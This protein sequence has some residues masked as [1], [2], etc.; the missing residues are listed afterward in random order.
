MDITGPRDGAPHKVGAAIGDLVSGSVRGAGHPGGALCAQ[1]HRARPACQ[2]LHV[3]GRGVAADLQ[4]QH[5]LRHRQLAAPPR[6]RASHHRALRD[7]RGG[8]RLDQ[9]GRRQRRSVA[10][11]LQRR[12]SAT[13]LNERS[14]ASPRRRIACATARSSCRWSGRIIKERTRDEWLQRLDKAGVP[15]GAIRTVGEVCDSDLLKA[16]GMIAEMPHASAGTVKAIKNAVHLSG[17]PLDGY[18]AP[19]TLGQ[20]TREVLTGLLG[21]TARARSMRWRG[22]GDLG[23]TDCNVRRPACGVPR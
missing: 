12:R 1:G 18:V 17:T 23:C 20:H 15:S 6:Q 22:Q 5:L 10:A 3:R 9:S 16:R 19:P 4:R 2:H 11:L 13:D 21:Y 7:V 14:H 8:R